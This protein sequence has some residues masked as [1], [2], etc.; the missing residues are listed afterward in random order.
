M[1]FNFGFQMFVR[2]DSGVRSGWLVSIMRIYHAYGFEYLAIQGA[3]DSLNSIGMV[4][5]PFAQYC[6]CVCVLLCFVDPIL[7]NLTVP[8]S[9]VLGTSP[10]F[11]AQVSPAVQ[12]P[13][14]SRTG[15]VNNT[16]TEYGCVI[17]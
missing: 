12:K 14:S 6:V 7:G 10:G 16:E 2:T 13:S 3:V 17:V 15:F 5:T 4:G 9:T 8:G 11:G 1:R